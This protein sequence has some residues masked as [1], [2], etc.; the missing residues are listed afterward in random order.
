[1]LCGASNSI[2]AAATIVSVD[3]S[4]TFS[5]SFGLLFIPC[6]INRSPIV[7]RW[8]PLE[9]AILDNESRK[10]ANDVDPSKKVTITASVESYKRLKLRSN[11]AASRAG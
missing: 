3:K 8:L 10:H 1:M 7:L 6:A 5:V 11:T 9:V 2:P 4:L